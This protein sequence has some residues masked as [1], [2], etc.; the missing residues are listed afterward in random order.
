MARIIVAISTVLC[1][2]LA[3]EACQ[4]PAFMH[5]NNTQRDWR[6]R[7]K[8]QHTEITLQLTV[9][10][11]TLRSTATD[12]SANSFAWVCLQQQAKDRFMVAH[13]E[14][15]QQGT[16]Y[17]CVEFVQRSD[18]V[19][20]IRSATVSKRMS[21]GL[22]TD[23]AMNLDPWLLIDKTHVAS[24]EQVCAL[25]G[26][27][28]IR[29]YDKLYQQG[30]CDGYHGE[31]RLESECMRGEGL[32]FY[33]RQQ[34]C[35]PDSLYMYFTQRTI[36]LANWQEG[37]YTFMLLRHDM[38]PQYMW[39]MRFPTVLTGQSFTAY[40]FKDL[41]ADVD[42]PV[43]SSQNYLRLDM[44][45]DSVR[46]VSSLCVD[47]YEVCSVWR[48]PC[49][50]GSQ[51]A[52]TCSRTCGLC[53]ATR[54]N[55]CAFPTD[56]Q[57]TWYDGNRLESP[58][59]TADSSTL[60]MHGQVEERFYCVDWDTTPTSS[61]KTTHDQMLVA[62]FHNGCKPRYTCAQI[63]QHS[64]NVMRLKMSQ[65]LRWPFTSSIDEPI[66]CTHFTY[67]HERTFLD[68]KYRSKNARILLA[69]D[70]AS[71]VSCQ[72]PD[73][74]RNFVAT[75]K[76]GTECM[77][78]TVQETADG[79]SMQVV[80]SDQCSAASQLPSTLFS[81]MESV[82]TQY[83]DLVVVVQATNTAEDKLFC[84]VFPRRP[85]SVF[86]LLAGNEC[87]EAV[88]RRIRN[89]RL[90]PLV[91]FSKRRL[92]DSNEES[93]SPPEEGHL[94]EIN[95][96]SNTDPSDLRT[97]PP[98]VPANRTE[99]DLEAVDGDGVNPAPYVVLATVLIFAL[100]QIPC[101]CKTSS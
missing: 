50:S 9:E 91:T 22:C 61:D 78:S 67:D 96:P 28:S 74:M 20:Q 35:V 82:R 58:A 1:S 55:V 69:K 64:N 46:P 16:R 98:P 60:T 31:T 6:G 88:R 19:V 15:G 40:L 90:D 17:T 48:E 30:V 41:V 63:A 42:S 23:S 97:K 57:G 101:I 86:Y 53:N 71:A 59:M 2:L 77:G 5:T 39:L 27:F 34:S 84:W 68:S 89:S 51:M 36:C 87:N 94:P 95:P 99:D 14:S 100:F 43:T 26:G 13:E 21:N 49:T 18:N 45:R 66:D 65:T 79:N 80:L 25:E 81:C 29:I 56:W 92:R 7:I 8:E 38:M 73:A 93:E 10:G 85:R 44:V 54:P 33:F 62:E 47:D 12:S 52:L 32:F 24:D 70:E 83:K 11:N 3:A 37:P 76:D 75:F 72:I 4:F